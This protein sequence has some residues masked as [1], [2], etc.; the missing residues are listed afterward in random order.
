M[1]N[2]AKIFLIQRTISHLQAIQPKNY[3]VPTDI[4]ISVALAAFSSLH[5][6][7]VLLHILYKMYTKHFF[8][9]LV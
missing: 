1:D 9:M 7:S 2:P 5:R 8:Q 6:N 3:H 4:Y